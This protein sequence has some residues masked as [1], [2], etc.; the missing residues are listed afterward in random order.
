MDGVHILEFTKSTAFL[1]Y[2]L[3][4]NNITVDQHNLQPFFTPKN[5][6]PLTKIFKNLQFP[7]V[8][9]SHAIHDVLS[10]PRPPPLVFPVDPPLWP[11]AARLAAPSVSGNIG[12]GDE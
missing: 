11:A 3:F 9:S 5:L 4:K 6:H 12:V 2:Y 1:L 10:L 7:L 8:G